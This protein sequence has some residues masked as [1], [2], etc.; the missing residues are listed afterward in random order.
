M[1]AFSDL[2]RLSRREYF[3]DFFITPPITLCLAV[4]SVLNS[5]SVWWLPLFAA[6]LLTWTFYEYVVHRWVSHALPVFKYLHGLHHAAQKDYIALH[7]AATLAIYAAFWLAFGSGSS[8]FMVGFSVGYIIYA[9]LHTLFHYARIERG[10]LLFAAK[11][12]HA[13]HHRIDSVNFGV[14]SGLWDAVFGTLL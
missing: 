2:F 13:L 5:F 8:A 9:T 12:R 10:G 1:K 14:S 4:V 6:G 3:A 7:P 11:Q